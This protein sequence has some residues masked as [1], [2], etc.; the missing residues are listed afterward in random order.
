MRPPHLTR[1][2]SV[3]TLWNPSDPASN[4]A[5]FPFQGRLKGVHFSKQSPLKGEV[6]SEARRRGSK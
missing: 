3:S 1:Y 2:S 4:G 5:T 6:L